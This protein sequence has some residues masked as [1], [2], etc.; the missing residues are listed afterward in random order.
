MLSIFV[1][2]IKL[3]GRFGNVFF[4]LFLFLEMFKTD[5]FFHQWC[6]KNAIFS[7]SPFRAIK[8]VLNKEIIPRILITNCFLVLH[9]LVYFGAVG[10]SQN[11]LK[12]ANLLQMVILM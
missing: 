7:A 1:K 2:F 3:A 8:Q 11:V 12:A 10:W 4:C 5:G 9:A 6:T